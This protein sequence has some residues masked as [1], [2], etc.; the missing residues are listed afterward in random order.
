M[1]TKLETPEEMAA[2]LYPPIGAGSRVGTAMLSAIRAAWCLRKRRRRGMPV[3]E[4][5]Q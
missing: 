5:A 4:Q 3:H 2:R 1:A